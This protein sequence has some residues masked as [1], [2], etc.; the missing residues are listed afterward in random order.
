MNPLPYGVTDYHGHKCPRN[1]AGRTV[2][3]GVFYKSAADARLAP[4]TAEC[5]KCIAFG[6]VAVLQQARIYLVIDP[7]IAG[8]L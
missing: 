6:P 7:L 5:R 4:T 8:K 3:A 2:N 1:D